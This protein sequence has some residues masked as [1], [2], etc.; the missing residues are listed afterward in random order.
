MIFLWLLAHTA[1]LQPCIV[2]CEGEAFSEIHTIEK[3]IKKIVVLRGV[4][5]D[6]GE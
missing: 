4:G 5:L 3:K 1:S 6:H 2:V